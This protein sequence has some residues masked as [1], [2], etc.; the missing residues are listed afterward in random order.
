M[1][2]CPG[3]HR[4][5]FS[6]MQ[7]AICQLNQQYYNNVKK[8]TDWIMGGFV[9]YMLVYKC[10]SYAVLWMFTW[11]SRSW[12][13]DLAF[14]KRVHSFRKRVVLN[15][16]VYMW[17]KSVSTLLYMVHISPMGILLTWSTRS[18]NGHEMGTH[19]VNPCLIQ[20]STV[21]CN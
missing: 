1:T 8:L 13:E 10:F 21:I 9:C 12:E 11:V 20:W 18:V 17:W 4:L 16:C 5:P 6:T 15:H 3:I 2:Q 19:K 14:V 7:V